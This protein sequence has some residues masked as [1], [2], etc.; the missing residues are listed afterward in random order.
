[1]PWS[2]WRSTRETEG[3]IPG[4][5]LRASRQ[6]AVHSL[7]KS[8]GIGLRCPDAPAAPHCSVARFCFCARFLQPRTRSVLRAECPLARVDAGGNHRQSRPVGSEANARAR[9]Y[10]DRS[11]EA[12]R[13]RSPCAGD[14]RP[15]ARARTHGTRLEH[16]RRACRAVGPRQSGWSRTTIPPPIR[17]G[18]QTTGVG[19][20]VS[21][22]AARVLAARP[23]GRG[24]RS[25]W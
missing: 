19:V 5:P 24:R 10:V 17:Q 25:S 18:P 14:G 12:V 23:I 11:A 6:S 4:F 15:A 2:E 1:M 7:A 9:A 21:L 20:A 3:L 16:H 8:I 13:L 22:E